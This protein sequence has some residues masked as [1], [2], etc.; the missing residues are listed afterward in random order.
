M[1]KDSDL[2]GGLLESGVEPSPINQFRLWFAAAEKTVPHLPNAMTL[3]TASRDGNPSAR[4]VL[5]KGFDENGFVFYT[6]YDSPKALELD[7]NPRAALL[8]FWPELERQVRIT[9]AVSRVSR[10]ESEEYFHTRPFD[11]QVGA[12]VSH[13]SEVVSG[14]KEL[15]E[16]FTQLCA[17]YEG[18]EVPLPPYWGGYRLVPDTIEFWLSR[19]ARLHD[20]IRYTRTGSSWTIERLSP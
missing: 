18:R 15:E 20:R 12:W 8:F 14:R 9:G 7:V 17:E 1:E 5:L 2:N 19:P 6:N 13:Q 3:A 16:R 11:S 10:E 4:M